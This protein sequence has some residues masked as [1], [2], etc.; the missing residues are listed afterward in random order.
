MTGGISDNWC[1]LR[2][3]RLQFFFAKVVIKLVRPLR[4]G[5]T[6]ARWTLN[7]LILVRIQVPQPFDSGSTSSPSLMAYF[8]YILRTSSNTLYTGQTDNLERRLKDHREKS[9]RSAKYIRYFPSFDLVYTETFPSRIEAMRR[10]LQLKRW[11]KAEKEALIY[12]R[13]SI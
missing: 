2:S 5:A 1:C 9:S 7:P 11:S 12:N 3:A 6:V 13:R 4:D 10:E 8:V